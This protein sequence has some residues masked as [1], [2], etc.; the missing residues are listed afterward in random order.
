[1][2]WVWNVQVHLYIDL[3][4][5][6]KYVLQYYMFWGWLNVQMWIHTDQGL[7]VKLYLGFLLWNRGNLGVWRRL[8]LLDLVL[9][10]KGNCNSLWLYA[11]PS[12]PPRMGVLP[13]ISTLA[14]AGTHGLSAWVAI[15]SLVPELSGVG[16]LSPCMCQEALSFEF[17]VGTVILPQPSLDAFQPAGATTRVAK[18]GSDGVKEQ[19]PAVWRNTGRTHRGPHGHQ[20]PPAFWIHY[21]RQLWHALNCLWDYSPIVFL[22]NSWLL[23]RWL[24][25]L[26]I[27]RSYGHTPISLSVFPIFFYMD[28][29]RVFKIFKFCF[30]F[31]SQFGL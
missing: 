16:V 31:G 30:S 17:L 13:S 8:V 9:L 27:K 28:R 12:R 11:L 22:N 19:E 26:L 15:L 20:W 18:E 4:F 3:F 1:M 5:F 6:K 29:L 2:T 23:L 14:Q 10:F 25:N 21:G 24:I 7:T